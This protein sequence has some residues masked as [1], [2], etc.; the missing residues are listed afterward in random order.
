MASKQAAK[1][2]RAN[3]R[4]LAD[5][6]QERGPWRGAQMDQWV[7]GWVRAIQELTRP[8]TA[9]WPWISIFWIHLNGVLEEIAPRQRSLQ[10]L[11]GDDAKWAGLPMGSLLT[12]VVSGLDSVVAAF[13]EDELIFAQYARHA[14]AHVFQDAYQLGGNTAK[15]QLVEKYTV[16]VLGKEFCREELWRRIGVVNARYGDS[17]AAAVAFARKVARPAHDLRAAFRALRNL[18]TSKSQMA[19]WDR[20]IAAAI[21]AKLAT[22]PE[23]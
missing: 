9:E 23:S 3:A 17:R 7:E 10:K 5:S 16:A 8:A 21:D 20:A 6:I 19:A 4:R 11:V 13:T 22:L 1:M 18:P 12:N 14:S 2:N 15:P